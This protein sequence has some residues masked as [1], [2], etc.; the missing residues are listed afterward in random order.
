MPDQLPDDFRIDH[1]G[2]FGHPVQGVDELLDVADAFLEQIADARTVRRVEQVL[3]VGALDVLAEHQDGQVRL[4][5][6]QLDR[7]PQALVG[8]AGRHPYIGHHD[9]RVVFEDRLGQFLSSARSGDHLMAETL[10]Q[11]DQALP[12]EHAVLGQNDAQH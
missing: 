4:L 3:G 8:E 7:G 5:L 10:Q 12:Q 2:A 9:V 11:T 6:A 1:R